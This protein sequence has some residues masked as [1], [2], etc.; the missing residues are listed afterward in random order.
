MFLRYVLRFRGVHL[1]RNENDGFY[2]PVSATYIYVFDSIFLER[3][4]RC[5]EPLVS[6]A[7]TYIQY[8]T[9]KIEALP[10]PSLT[11]PQFVRTAVHHGRSHTAQNA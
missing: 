9:L 11:L 10:F 5:T 4:A 7:Y 6:T 3:G 8:L 2:Y 1:L